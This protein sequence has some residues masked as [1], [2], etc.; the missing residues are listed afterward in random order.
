MIRY[1]NEFKNLGKEFFGMKYLEHS[2][3]GYSLRLS[4]IPSHTIES[5]DCSPNKTKIHEKW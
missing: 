4:K 2:C 1:E 3:M 5:N